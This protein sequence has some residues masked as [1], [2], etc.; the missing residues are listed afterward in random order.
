MR[1]KTKAFEQYL[2][3]DI[4]DEDAAEE[5]LAKSLP[6]IGEVVMY[7]NGLEKCLDSTLCEEFTDRTDFTGLIVLKGMLYGAKVDLFARFE[8]NFI[9][10]TGLTPPKYAGLIKELKDLGT[11][12]NQVVHADWE[13]TDEEGYTYVRLHVSDRGMVQEYV[14]FS[15][16]SLLKLVDRITRARD[17]LDEYWTE[18]NDMLNGRL[19]NA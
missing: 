11:Y 8:D 17:W 16:E 12:R 4:E 13:N 1:K 15:E 19:G 10:S 14:Q 6:L 7:F 18:R 3:H 2:Y 9:V 5:Y